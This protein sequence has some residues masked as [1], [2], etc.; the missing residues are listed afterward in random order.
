MYA[1]LLAGLSLGVP[2]APAQTPEASAETGIVKHNN[3]WLP[4]RASVEGEQVDVMFTVI[5]V[6]TMIAMVGVFA[7]LIVFLIKYRYRSGRR[8]TFIHGHHQAEVIWTLTPAVILVVL[9]I[10]SIRVWGQLRMDKPGPERRT[11]EIEVLA[12]QFNWNFRY[13]GRDGRF[14]TPDDVGSFEADSEKSPLT[15]VFRVPVGRTVRIHLMSRD[16]L[17][18]FFLPNMRIKMDAVPGLR[19]DLWFTPT[20]VGRYDLACAELCGP[21]HYTMA[22]TLIVMP[23]AE[24]DAWMKERQAEVADLIGEEMPAEAAPAP[25]SSEK[26][27]AP[28][29][30][31]GSAAPDS[32]EGQP[33]AEIGSEPL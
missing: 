18:S 17:H 24:F 22:G 21:Q 20:Q 8:A 2:A 33:P 30:K 27:A 13:P 28:A 11:T 3:W 25:E 15:G 29:E 26:S 23:Q 7:V 5:F 4:P 1:A 14:G 6:V 12:Q 31:A 19:G 10:L 9:G 32:G 16:V